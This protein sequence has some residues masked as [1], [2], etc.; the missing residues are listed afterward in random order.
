VLSYGIEFVAG[1]VVLA[2]AAGGLTLAAAYAAFRRLLG[3]G[4]EDPRK[5]G[6]PA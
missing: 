3:A 6:G 5:T 4:Q 1:S 2:V